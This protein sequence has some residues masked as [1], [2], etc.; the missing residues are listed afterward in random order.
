MGYKRLDPQD[1]AV[2][3][4]QQKLLVIF[5]VILLRISGRAQ[6]KAAMEA[7]AACVQ[8]PHVV[9]VPLPIPG[10]LN[11]FTFLANYLASCGLTVT[12]VH[13]SR[14]ASLLDSRPQRPLQTD[15]NTALTSS[16]A[17]RIHVVP[18][19]LSTDLSQ[20]LTRAPVLASFPLMQQGLESFLLQIALQHNNHCP[21]TYLLADCFL[22]WTQH[23][24]RKFNIPRI[25]VWLQSASVFSMAF[26]IPELI[27][28]GCLP[29]ASDN[30]IVDFIPG[31]P[32]FPLSDLPK[33]FCAEDL[34]SPGFQYFVSMFSHLNEADR[35]LVHSFYDLESPVIDALR[36]LHVRV[37]AIGPLITS[38]SGQKLLRDE[39]LVPEDGS[40][41]EWL[42]AQE[43]CS[44]LYVSFGSTFSP[45]AEGFKEL[46]LGLEASQQRFL[47][48]IRPDELKTATILDVLPEGFQTRTQG[49]SRIV[50]WAPQ[51]S[52]LGHPAVGAFLTH[53]GW[54]ST[55]ESL[56]MGVPMIGF[57][58]WADQNTNLKCILDW[59]IGTAL[60]K[61]SRGR[62]EEAV[63]EMMAGEEGREARKTARELAEVARKAMKE[64]SS[65][66]TLDKLVQDVRQGR[67]ECPSTLSNVLQPK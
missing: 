66:A 39:S 54:N 51:L 56:N 9:V 7:V 5:S 57:P 1:T 23:V 33:G 35:V 40:C 42:D 45:G 27:A 20:S 37:D 11:P 52:V 17:P 26:H 49:R 55:I 15:A 65:K 13:S 29:L 59:K 61:C 22:P 60:G 28:K 38:G 63:R 2:G 67:L 32:P 21:N 31:L 18:D 50:S 12:L 25:A 53:C 19:V 41:L 6:R 48:V 10:H 64:G 47:W 44:V 16:N 3:Q 62:V 36:A 34:N 14:A 46:A 30:K 58:Q 24:A 43:E 4:S 8:T